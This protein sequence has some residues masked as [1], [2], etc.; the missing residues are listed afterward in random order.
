MSRSFVCEDENEII[1]YI[2]DMMDIH[3]ESEGD[4]FIS[5]ERLLSLERETYLAFLSDCG[6]I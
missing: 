2:Q 3:Y 5:E 1:S 6:Y 4:D